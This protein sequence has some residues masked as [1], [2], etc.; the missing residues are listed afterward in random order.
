MWCARHRFP[1]TNC[2]VLC[3]DAFPK[4]LEFCRTPW[5]EQV[6]K[7]FEMTLPVI[8]INKEFLCDRYGEW[9]APIQPGMDG[10]GQV[11]HESPIDT[12]ELLRE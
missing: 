11:A 6:G 4:Y 12:L 7:T 10:Y 5:R 9:G 2:N 1:E 3:Q 8:R